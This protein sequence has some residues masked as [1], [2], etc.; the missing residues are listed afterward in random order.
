MNPEAIAWLNQQ[1][2]SGEYQRLDHVDSVTANRELRGLVQTG[3]VIQN[4][5]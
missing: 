1:I 5:T 4:S 3:L 2:T